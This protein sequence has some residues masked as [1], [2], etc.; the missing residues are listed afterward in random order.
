MAEIVIKCCTDKNREDIKQLYFQA[1]I[2]VKEAKAQLFQALYGD[3]EKE[4]ANGPDKYM[5]YRT[6]D[7]LEATFTLKR[8]TQTFAKNNVNSGETLILMA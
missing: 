8:Q 5:L 7:Y 2:T 4:S 1:D 6:D 3:N